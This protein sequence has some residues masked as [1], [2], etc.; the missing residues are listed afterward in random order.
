MVRYIDS[1]VIWTSLLQYIGPIKLKHI[2]QL[3]P[4]YHYRT[5]QNY[6][7]YKKNL[8]SNIIRKICE[9]IINLEY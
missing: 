6:Y 7:H 2:C 5:G 4:G 3:G 1:Y 8:F 9:Y